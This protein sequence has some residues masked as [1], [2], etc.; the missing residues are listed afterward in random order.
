MKGRAVFFFV[1]L[2]NIPCYI[3]LMWLLSDR[4]GLNTCVNVHCVDVF[5]FRH[6]FPTFIHKARR[7]GDWHCVHLQGKGGV[8][9]SELQAASGEC[10]C[11]KRRALWL[12]LDDA[13]GLWQKTAGPSSQWCRHGVPTG[14]WT[15]ALTLVARYTLRG[16]KCYTLL[17]LA[18]GCS[19]LMMKH[20]RQWSPLQ[21]Q[22]DRLSCRV[23][24][25]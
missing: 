13:Q 1:C 6:R 19:V 25:L 8:R 14:A 17:L 23:Y 24:W 5:V 20:W 2:F 16:R 7:F 21:M 9:W 22:A 12:N 11:L 10:E 3:R 18:E 15:V 4:R